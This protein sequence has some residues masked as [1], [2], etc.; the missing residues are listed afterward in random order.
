MGKI[1][2]SKAVEEAKLDAKAARAEIEAFGKYMDVDLKGM[3]FPDIA[4]KLGVDKMGEAGNEQIKTIMNFVS[5]SKDALSV[6]PIDSDK[7]NATWQGIQDTITG[8]TTV[9]PL[10]ANTTTAEKQVATLANPKTVSVTADITKAEEQVA[11]LGG[12]VAVALD[13]TESIDNIRTSLKE[14]LELDISAKSGASG[15]LETIKGFVEQIKTAV[16][17]IEPKLPVAALVA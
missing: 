3:A 6:N 16:E 10:E 1:E 2:K 11:G 8:K 17:K 15:I 4:K 9:L 13:A 14:G 5:E 7:F 12:G